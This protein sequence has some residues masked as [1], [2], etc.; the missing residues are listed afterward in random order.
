M[1]RELW[2]G[3]KTRIT[4]RNR[5][6]IPIATIRHGGELIWQVHRKSERSGL[7]TGAIAAM[8]D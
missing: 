7:Q 8:T 1:Q 3:I 2:M 6:P 5:V 4:V